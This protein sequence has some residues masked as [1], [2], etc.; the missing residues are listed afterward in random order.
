MVPA[1]IR[2]LTC[3]LFVSAAAARADLTIVQDVQG[4]GS[5]SAMTIRIKGDKARMETTPQIST[6]IDSRTGDV[7]NL[8]HDSHK[9]VRVS[10]DRAKAMAEMATK[11]ASKGAETT[12]APKL[13]PTGRKE[14]IAGYDA[15][16]YVA[17]SPHYTAHYW[18]STTYPDAAALMQQLQAITP[19]SWTAGNAS[20]PDYRDLPGFPLRTE[21]S[22]GG[23]QIVSTLKSISR[24]PLPDTL[25][26]APADYK[27]MKLPDLS[28]LLGGKPDAKASPP[29]EEKRK[30]P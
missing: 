18:V 5:N 29:A 10:G 13:A 19:R 15:E 3:G 8:M 30:A 2:L 4:A 1:V 11:L 20:L 16:E 17:E 23:K 21:I 26:V 9:V 7:V 25:F 24:E 28:S 12:V 6:I 22:M 27:E 14:K